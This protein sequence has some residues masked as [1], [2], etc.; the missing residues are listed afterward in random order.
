VRCPPERLDREAIG[1]VVKVAAGTQSWM[2][3]V[4]GGTGQAGMAGAANLTSVRA[5]LEFAF[6]GRNPGRHPRQPGT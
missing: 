1:A 3:Q 2:R 4:E 5:L 6:T